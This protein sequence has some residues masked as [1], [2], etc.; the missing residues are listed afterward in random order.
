MKTVVVAIVALL[1]AARWSWHALAAIIA[2]EVL[3]TVLSL[4]LHL[5]GIGVSKA[6][7]SSRNCAACVTNRRVALMRRLSE[8]FLATRCVI[9]I[10]CMLG[11]VC[12]TA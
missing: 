7:F 2:F 11:V 12:V 3:S 4:P 8:T 5:I 1:V 9:L 10:R 6:F